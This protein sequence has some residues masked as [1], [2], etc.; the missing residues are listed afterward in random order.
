MGQA[1]RRG[2]NAALKRWPHLENSHRFG[3]VT[4]IKHSWIYRGQILPENKIVTIDAVITEIRDEPQ[5]AIQ[6]D[7]YLIVD[8]LYIYKMENFG[9]QLV[10]VA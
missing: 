4:V 3:L 8:G 2:P 9:I 7:G 10:P 1:G 5:P 6:A